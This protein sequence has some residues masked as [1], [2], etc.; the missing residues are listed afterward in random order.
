MRYLVFVGHIDYP[1]GGLDDLLSTH[2][3]LEDAVETAARFV[4]NDIAC[5]W[6]QVYDTETG[7]TVYE[8]G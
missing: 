7:I 4:R 3:D 8:R 5:N 6:A 1:K 2:S